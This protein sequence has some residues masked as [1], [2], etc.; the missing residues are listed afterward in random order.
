MNIYTVYNNTLVY[1]P[2]IRYHYNYKCRQYCKIMFMK[3]ALIT[4]LY[5]IVDLSQTNIY[6]I[7]AMPFLYHITIHYYDN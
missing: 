7:D 6:I 4:A 5:V 3:L 1:S 2:K